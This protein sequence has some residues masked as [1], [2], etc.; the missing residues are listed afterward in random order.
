MAKLR[1]TKN[2]I[3]VVDLSIEECIKLG[4]GFVEKNMYILLCNMCNEVINRRADN[5]IHY[6]PVLNDTFCDNCMKE[7]EEYKNYE[8]DI[9]Y[10]NEIYNHLLEGN[11]LEGLKPVDMKWYADTY[12][13]RFTKE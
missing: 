2:G 10:Q 5:V 13:S 12:Q 11:I 4:Y 1:F 7:I 6:V 3:Y 8:E 9:E